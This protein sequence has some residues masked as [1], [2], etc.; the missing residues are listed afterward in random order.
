MRGYVFHYNMLSKYF[1]QLVGV[2]F[3]LVCFTVKS[4]QLTN[5][6][7]CQPISLCTSTNLLLYV[8]VDFLQ[9]YSLGMYF[10]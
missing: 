3:S 5:M 8:L 6:F 2:V 1:L 7:K 10:L 4:E 9:C